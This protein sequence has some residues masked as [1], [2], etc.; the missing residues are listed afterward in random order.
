MAAS[1]KYLCHTFTTISFVMERASL[2]VAQ[3]QDFTLFHS[4]IWS[5]RLGGS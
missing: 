5:D 2:M 4:H 1:L 3:T